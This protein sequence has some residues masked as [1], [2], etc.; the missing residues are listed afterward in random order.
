M[1]SNKNSVLRVLIEITLN[2]QIN[3]FIGI[4]VLIF[5]SY[6]MVYFPLSFGLSVICFSK[7]VCYSMGLSFHQRLLNTQYS[8]PTSCFYGLCWRDRDECVTALAFRE[9][10]LVDKR[11]T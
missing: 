5:L 2:L 7:N 3:F 6:N 10:S 8:N 4:F 11:E 1:F 9:L